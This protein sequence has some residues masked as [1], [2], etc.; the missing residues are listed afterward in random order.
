LN[1]SAHTDNVGADAANMSLSQ[2][3]AESVRNYFI[4]KGVDAA[5]MTAR[6]YGETQ[7]AADN[8]T[9]EGRAMNRRVEMEVTF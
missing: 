8:G 7:P 2:R 1:I 6:W 5:N 4:S 3:R 9:A